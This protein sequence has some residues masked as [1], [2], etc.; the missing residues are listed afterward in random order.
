MDEKF[1]NASSLKKTNYNI[2]S[3]RRNSDIDNDIYRMFNAFP[4]NLSFI[5][6]SSLNSHRPT[7]I[8]RSP[9]AIPYPYPRESPWDSHTNS[10]P[11]DLPNAAPLP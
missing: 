1:I 6:K 11:V 8:H 10:S 7:M 5:Q 9:R 2:N 3:I 4:L